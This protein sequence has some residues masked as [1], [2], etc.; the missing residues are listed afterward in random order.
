[1]RILLANTTAYK[2]FARDVRSNR[3]SHAYMLYFQDGANLRFALK[4]FALALFGVAEDSRE[5]SLIMSEGFSD[6]MVRPAEGKNPA[7]GDADDIAA[8]SALK[9]VEGNKKLFIFTHF[10]RASAVV[11]NKLLKLLEEPPE[12]VYFLLGATSLSPVLQTVRSR[13]K[14]LEIEPFSCEAVLAALNRRGG[15]GELNALAARSCSGNFGQAEAMVSEGWFKDILAAAR[16]ICSASTPAKAGQASMKYAEV[17]EREELLRQ[18]QRIYFEELKKCISSHDIYASTFT[19]PA[20]EYAVQAADR[21]AEDAKFNA[22]FSA[23]L[24]N[25]MTGVITEN[26]KWKKLLV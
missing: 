14:T 5:G 13:V 8:E 15:D 2:I 23:L 21:A 18:I 4:F 16:E 19:R 10:D 11:Q 17:K 7:V 22:N 6:M 1:M 3:L 26:D 24:F 9:P 12:G 25:L 20:L